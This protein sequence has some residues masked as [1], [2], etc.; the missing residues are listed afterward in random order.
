[1]LHGGPERVQH[2]GVGRDDRAHRRNSV[3]LQLTYTDPAA[4]T[5]SPRG[6]DNTVTYT[7]TNEQRTEDRLQRKEQRPTLKTVINLTNHTYFNL[8]GEGSGDVFNQLLKINANSYTPTDANLIPTGL[9][10]GGGDAVRLPSLKPI[11]QDIRDAC[12]AAGQSA[13]ARPRL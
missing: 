10:A 9:R 3:S 12:S 7:L 4:T 6:R 13:G 8:A 1:M 5:A 2:A 11:G